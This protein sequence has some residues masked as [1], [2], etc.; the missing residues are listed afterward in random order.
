[1]GAET[2]LLISGIVVFAL[3]TG[4]FVGLHLAKRKDNSPQIRQE[5]E[6]HKARLLSETEK[7]EELKQA[8]REINVAM[9]RLRDEK[10][11]ALILVSKLGAEK[12][13]VEKQ[14]DE[15]RADI[16]TMQEKF[17]KDFKLIANQIFEEKTENFSKRSK[18]SIDQL[19][20]PLKERLVSF[21][22]KV[23]ETHKDNLKETSGLKAELKTLREMSSK[24]T[25]EAENLTR[26][27]RND[28][29]IQ[30]NWGEMILENILEK[31]GLRKDEEYFL[32]QNFS[33]DEGRRFQPDVMIKLPDDKWVIV[34]SKVS[35]KA[36]EDFINEDEPKSK[37]RYLKNHLISLKNH[38]KGLSEKKYQE[39]ASG[40]NLDFILMFVPIEPAYLM[41]LQ[42]DHRL[43]NEAYD[44]GIV[45]V[46]PTTL[47]ASL[48]II[49]TTWKHEYQN[50]NALE[51]ADRGKLLLEKFVGFAE[52]F[53]KIGVQIDRTSAT[54]SDALKKLRDG[55]GSLVS[56][57]KQ[58]EQ[59]GVRAT[60]KLSNNLIGDDDSE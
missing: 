23:D 37:E 60:K 15:Q 46:S 34:D 52:D 17:T 53:E 43:F 14:I 28:T 31:S 12:S 25:E 48:K 56:Q 8:G 39:V 5:L 30:G 9:D 3:A 16:Q 36:Y 57:A 59:L 27:L 50:R 19:L 42:A 24:M 40:K 1:M 18:E 26:A 2:L 10:E 7:N 13:N 4:I 11:R 22:K 58:L 49:Q 21:E 41:A 44:R 35:L 51:I 47:I 45:M 6:E 54:Y 55:R 32:Q 38:I 20:S 33:T 29:K